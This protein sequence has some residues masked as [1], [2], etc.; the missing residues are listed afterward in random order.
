MSTPKTARPQAVIADLKTRSAPSPLEVPKSGFDCTASA[1]TF[2]AA[3]GCGPGISGRGNAGLAIDHTLADGCYK[4][5][6]ISVAFSELAGAFQ[7]GFDLRRMGSI[8]TFSL[9]LWR[10]LRN[11][12]N[13]SSERRRKNF[14][15]SPQATG[16]KRCMV[17]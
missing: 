12:A 8:L 3:T 5:V 13:P 1:L 2:A 4:G 11:V 9:Q 6:K 17:S 16:P 10:F 14:S 7:V 15:A